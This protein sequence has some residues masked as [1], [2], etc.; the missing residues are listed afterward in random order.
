MACLVRIPGGKKTKGNYNKSGNYYIKLW[1]PNERR[2]WH[3]PCKTKNKREAEQLFR[4]VKMS[5]RQVS[6]RLEADLRES[7]E[8]RLGL[9]PKLT[10]E[11]TIQEFL[12]ERSA[13]TEKSTIDS[14]KLSLKDLT[15]VFSPTTLI[16]NLKH[17][18]YAMLT[19]YLE[20]S[21]KENT[22]WLRLRSI[23][24]YFNWAVKRKLIKEKPF[25]M[26]IPK[27]KSV[28]VPLTPEEMKAIY[29]QVTDPVIYATFKCAEVTGIRR[30]DLFRTR[31]EGE[32]LFVNS[33]KSHKEY[34]PV[35]FAKKYHE[36]Y[37]IMIAANYHVDRI[38]RAFTTARRKVGWIPDDAGKTFHS[39]R[40]TF[41]LYMKKETGDLQTVCFLLGHDTISVTH[42]HYSNYGDQYL[43]DMFKNYKFKS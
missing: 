38:T 10:L 32:Y 9:K 12:K 29:S 15:D 3:I 31:L 14:Y 33:K 8:E 23:R 42:D 4:Q 30:S 39:F 13:I 11:S 37:Q 18:Q 28:K 41:A 16:T 21:Y 43:K 26:V 35:P 19:S 36:Y 5:E 2:S 24:A 7:I 17:S 6:A 27:L 22:K 20:S 34:G 40:H 25:D 1:L